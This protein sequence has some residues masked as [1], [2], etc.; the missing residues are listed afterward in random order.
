[1]PLPP[2]LRSEPKKTLP[3]RA[4]G[5]YLETYMFPRPSFLWVT[6][7]VAAV[8]L[9]AGCRSYSADGEAGKGVRLAET[10]DVIRVELDGQLFT[11]YH[12]RNVSRPFLYPLLSADGEHLTRRWP[13]EDVPGE[14]HDHP[15]HHAM[16]YSHGDAN[17]VAVVEGLASTA[18]VITAAAAIMICVFGSFVLGDMRSIKLIGLGLAVAVFIDATVV[19][20]VLVPATMEL[21]GDRNWWLPRGLGR[22]LPRLDVEGRRPKALAQSR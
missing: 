16:W 10:N 12:F 13:Q 1:M 11:E 20:M 19:R 5:G 18:R 8:L 17:G 4:A 6:A 7:L 22:L 15:H 21:L 9:G 3:R 14:E 2:G